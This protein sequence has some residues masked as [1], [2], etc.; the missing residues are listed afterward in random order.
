[1]ELRITATARDGA[2]VARAEDGRVVFVE[3]A[4]PGETVTAEITR[5]DK[6]WSRGRVVVVS[7]PSP[8]RVPVACSHQLEG[9]GGCDLLHVEAGAAIRM[10]Q[11]MVVDQ[12]VRAEVDAPAPG[13]RDLDDDH[14]RTTVR[15]AVVRGRAGY[16]IRS[17]NDI[18]VPDDCD[19]VDPLVEELL[20]DGRF[21]DAEEIQIRV[22]NRTGE[23]LVVVT[24]SDFGIELPD[25]VALV[26]D[27]QLV[28]GKRAWI[29]EE[30]AGRSWRISARSFFQNRPAGVD[31]LVAEVQE[32]VDEYGVDGP[33][34]DAYAGIGIFGGTIGANRPVH[35][36]ERGR[37]SVADARVNLVDA[38][39]KIVKTD[40]ARW[41]SSPAGVVIA[42]PAREGLGK[43]A[44]QTLV[45]AE[46]AVLVLV[47]CD[48]GSFGRD[49]KLLAGAGYELQRYTVIDMFP[50]TSHVET[51]AAFTPA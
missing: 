17:S 23:R 47:S 19:A 39:A 1:M 2:G 41:R 7:D 27:T 34:V 32:M 30:A 10:K 3:G 46:P 25:D 48:P 14:G 24:G 22:G 9:C 43:G 49:A 35:A 21:G 8:D 45:R 28:A 18:V 36:I 15:A 40:V 37:D 12:L 29:H 16:R 5:V 20:V 6:R 50:G 42:D 31:A 11:S 26:T 33:L 13:L 38:D 44:V 4:L 51:V